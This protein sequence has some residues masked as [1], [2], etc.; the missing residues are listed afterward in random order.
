M[1]TLFK[2]D[3]VI[4]DGI[5]GDAFRFTNGEIVIFGDKKEAIDDSKSVGGK[6]IPCTKL[7]WKLQRELI[8]QINH[9]FL[10]F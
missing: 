6:V 7:P 1:K 8:N 3:Y 9:K 4:Y 5:K 2:T 10:F